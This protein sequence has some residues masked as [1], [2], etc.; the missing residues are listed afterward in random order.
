LEFKFCYIF[1][2]MKRT[3][4]EYVIVRD[5]CVLESGYRYGE[6]VE[7]VRGGIRGDDEVLVREWGCV[8]GGR[9]FDGLY[10]DIGEHDYISAVNYGNNINT[11]YGKGEEV[12]DT[13]ADGSV[14]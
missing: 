11:T 13:G 4:Y 14:V 1:A 5:E 3:L 7:H 10:V 8:C 6:S 9:R 2:V 12:T